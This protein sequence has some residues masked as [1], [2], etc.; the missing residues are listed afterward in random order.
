VMDIWNFKKWAAP[1]LWIGS[2]AITIYMVYTLLNVSSIGSWLAKNIFWFASKN[3][4]VLG[5]AI[6]S[7]LL[8]LLLAY[9]MFRRKIFLRL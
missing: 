4:F 7:A 3:A 6:L 8:S 2:N 5:G 9:I 1:F